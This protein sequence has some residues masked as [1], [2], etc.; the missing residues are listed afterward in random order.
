MTD[1]D[2][3]KRLADTRHQLLNLRLQS[4][5]RP[6]QDPPPL[7]FP[8]LAPVM[9]GFTI[10]ADVAICSSSGWAHGAGATGRRVV[11]CHAPA[12]W[13]YQRER[14]VGRDR[15][16]AAAVALLAPSLRRWDA[17]AAARADRYLVN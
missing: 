2:L 4:P 7:A 1:E 8:F 17:R 14:Y 13:L 16:R 10:D 15:V 5:T 11:Y 3:A 6:P 12:R 9:S